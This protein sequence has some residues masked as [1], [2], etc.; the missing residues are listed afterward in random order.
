MKKKLFCIGLSMI[1]SLAASQPPFLTAANNQELKEHINK[2]PLKEKIGQLF[3][4]AAASNFN[5]P[6]E[7][8]ASSMRSCPYQMDEEHV[9]KMITEY[10]VGGVIF[11]FKSDPKTQRAYIDKFQAASKTPLLIAQDCEWGLSMRLDADQTKVVRYP[12]N[13]TLGALHDEQLIYELGKEIGMQCAVNGIHMNLAPVVDVNN[14]AANPV[15]HDRSFGDDP[16]RVARLASL[17]ARGLQDAGVLACAKHFPGHGDTTI[18]SHLDLPI[19]AHNQERLNDIELVP[20]KEVIKQGISAIMTAHLSVPAFDDTPNLP[21]SM[22]HKIIRNILRTSL[23]FEGLVVSDGLGMQAITKHFAPGELELKAVLAGNQLLLCPLNVPRAIDLIEQAIGNNLISE[24]ELDNH[25]LKILRAKLWAMEQQKQYAGIN[26]DDFLVRPEALQLQRQ[27]Y[28]RALTIAKL[29]APLDFK[30]TPIDRIYCLQI[31]TLQN[32]QLAQSLYTK[33]DYVSEALSDNEIAHAGKEAKK[34]DQCVVFLG[35]MN[36]FIDKNFGVSKNIDSLL[37]TLKE[38]KK[39]LTVVLFG[40]PYATA[41]VHQAD[42]IV[43]AYE[44]A[45]AMQEVVADF[46]LGKQE[47]SGRLPVK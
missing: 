25:V 5:Q 27:L 26:P 28:S 33:L 42:N 22:S 43:V 12:R 14:N 23:E 6:T 18:D 2:M 38:S 40:T 20:F 8:L 16:Q 4:V 36:K 44:D 45:P 3:V 21:S 15:I 10:K 47:A 11:L 46:L 39:P 13:M 41:K 34:H 24:D 9:M 30:Q 7:A 29:S 37:S 31:G 19:I 17:Y 1:L 32:N 35:S